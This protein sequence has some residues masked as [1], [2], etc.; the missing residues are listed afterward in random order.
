MDE[1]RGIHNTKCIL[2]CVQIGQKGR[3]SYQRKG[4]KPV[5]GGVCVKMERSISN[6]P[7]LAERLEV[8]ALDEVGQRLY[9]RNFE[10]LHIDS[11]EKVPQLI[12]ESADA[13]ESHKFSLPF[14]ASEWEQVVDAGNSIRGQP[15]GMSDGWVGRH[16]CLKNNAS[17]CGQFLNLSGQI[18]D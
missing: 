1:I 2:Q 16:G 11:R 13:V 14:L 9:E 3:Y 15:I 5:Y 7:G 6:Q 17:Y 8:H 18:V 12:A 10:S 4:S